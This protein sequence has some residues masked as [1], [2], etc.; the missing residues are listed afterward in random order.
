MPTLPTYRRQT[1]ATGR[2]SQEYLC[3]FRLGRP[4]GHLSDRDSLVLE[5]SG[6][7]LIAAVKKHVLFYA[8]LSASLISVA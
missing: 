7:L 1:L 2:C 8:N 3:G 5:P 4:R 6:R